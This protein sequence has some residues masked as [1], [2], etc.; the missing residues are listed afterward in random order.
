LEALGRRIFATSVILFFVAPPTFV[1]WIAWG[2]LARSITIFV[3][4]LTLVLYAG[5][6]LSPVDYGARTIRSVE[7]SKAPP[8]V[9]KLLKK[10]TEDGD[11][12]YVILL[13]SFHNSEPL[14]QTDM[15]DYAQGKGVDLTAQQ[16]RSYIVNM[17]K[18]RWISSPKVRYSKEYQLTEAGKWCRECFPQRG[19]MYYL[20][21]GLGLLRTKQYPGIVP[22][23]P[24]ES[25]PTPQSAATATPTNPPET[26]QES[27]G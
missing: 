10:T 18:F 20:R 9:V 21:N 7:I 13:R 8:E 12:I 16:I 17:E 4:L 24:V 15:T 19:F 23:Q 14:S 5:L 22:P 25:A 11:L 1:I 2:I 3:P 6:L 27:K 26:H